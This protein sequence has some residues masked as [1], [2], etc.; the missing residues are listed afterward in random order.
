MN[1]DL[2]IVLVLLSTAILM[3]AFNR[4][5]MDVVGLIMLTALPLTGVITL[6]E[7]LKGFSDPAVVLIALLFVIGEALSRTGVAKRMGDWLVRKAGNS[8]IRL[9]SLLMLLVAG[10]G[11]FMSSTG[12]VAIFIPIVL[13]IAQNASIPPSRL[14]M[15]LAFAGLMS[16]MMTLVATPPNLV[17]NSAVRSS[18]HAGFHFFAFLPF[19]LPILILAIIYM[20]SIRHVFDNKEAKV[21]TVQRPHLSDW[22]REY[23]L[24][25]REFR[26]RILKG[27]P[28]IGKTLKDLNL[29]ALSGVNILAIER[30]GHFGQEILIPRANV[31]LMAED[32][33]M[34]DLSN[35]PENI[36]NI[37]TTNK[38]KR[39]PLTGHYFMDSSQEIGMA[40]V[41][42]PASSRFVD[43]TLAE[44]QFDIQF[45]LVAV[46]MKRKKKAVEGSL[47]EERLSVGDTLLVVG[48]WR[49]I[50][51]LQANTRD[52][53]LL[54]LPA[55]SDDVIPVPQKAPHA[56]FTL[57]IVIFLM[58]TGLVPNVLAG[59]I[60]C[61]LLG[62]FRCIDMNAAY[63]SIHW[64][65]IILIVGM[66]P[67]SFA[68]Q[69]T[70]GIDLAV[71]A[72]LEVAGQYSPRFILSLLFIMTALLGL[73]ISNTATA[74]LMAPVAIALANGLNASP[75]PFAMT[76]ALAASTAFMTPVSSPVNALVLG[77]GNYK[78]FDFVKVG[79]PFSIIT[80]IVCI[81]LIPIFMP[82]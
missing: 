68:L 50:K 67:F 79:V 37:C 52:L 58:V 30:K 59:L 62:L 21:R 24:H 17:V 20:I 1:A 47:L 53:V 63:R 77:P 70:G 15:P 82:L 42:I 29:H 44:M 28:F 72:L 64:Q 38:L 18:G 73:F 13:R 22:I 43:E 3:F 65:S 54:D 40:E 12:V 61:L 26:V 75:Y 69:K 49:S 19:G 7:A 36:D 60:G 57:G 48:T 33:L 46:G 51:R 45:D 11:S 4:P 39:L 35:T 34:I 41:M 6:D 78:F 55:E 23:E 8:E 10:I 66:L 25:K 71:N 9:I 5:R 31:E 2:I 56:L 32:A 74:V 76:V 16:G 80:M 27:S 14:M 81:T